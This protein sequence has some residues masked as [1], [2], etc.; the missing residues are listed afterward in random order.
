MKKRLLMLALLGAFAALPGMAKECDHCEE[1]DGPC[2]EAAILAADAALQNDVAAHGVTA[3]FTAAFTDDGQLIAAGQPLLTGKQAV[4]SFLQSSTPKG[5]TLTWIIGRGDVSAS[6]DLGYTWGWTIFTAP[7]GTPT[8]GLYM[9]MWR[10]DRGHGDRSY[11]LQVYLRYTADPRLPPPAGFGPVAPPI[12]FG[13]RVDPTHALAQLNV[14]D[15]EFSAQ[16]VAQGQPAAHAVF[17]APDAVELLTGVTYGRDAIV[18]SHLDDD[19]VLSWT[20]TGGGVSE[21]GDLGYT[22]GPFLVTVPGTTLTAAGHYLTIWKRQLDGQWR[23]VVGS[24]A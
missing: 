10:R 21:S 19:F 17:A 16:A 11:S 14:L 24:G 6:G 13:D 7:G 1:S 20:S 12:D 18:A 23:Y 8:P 22:T 3:G 5:S 15:G 9:A 4:V 2:N